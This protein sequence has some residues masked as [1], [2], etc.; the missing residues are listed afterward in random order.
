MTF[1]LDSRVETYHLHQ[2]NLVKNAGRQTEGHSGKYFIILFTKKIKIK[3]P[4][5]DVNIAGMFLATCCRNKD[6]F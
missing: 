2:N 3:G 1:L 4:Y 5:A 6:V